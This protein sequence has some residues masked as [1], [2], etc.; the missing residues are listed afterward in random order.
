MALNPVI[1]SPL[2]LLWWETKVQYMRAACGTC[3]STSC[4]QVQAGGEAWE[5]LG[6]VVGWKAKL[7]VCLCR[8]LSLA[9]L[10]RLFVQLEAH[11]P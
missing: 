7:L 9:K 4:P 6:N 1:R 10:S 8:A 11:L 3:D 2:K 5:G